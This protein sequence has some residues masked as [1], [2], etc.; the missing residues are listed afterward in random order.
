MKFI[1]SSKEEYPTSSWIKELAKHL[2]ITFESND[3]KIL[4]SKKPCLI[5]NPIANIISSEYDWK[6]K[7]YKRLKQN[8]QTVYTVERGYLPDCLYIDKYGALANSNSYNKKN[9]DKKLSIDKYKQVEKY[10]KSFIEDSSTL[11]EQKRGRIAEEG[12]YSKLRIKK[13]QIKV[14]VPLQKANDTV[15]LL[16]SDWIKGIKKFKTT[17][18]ELAQENPDILFLVKSHPRRLTNKMRTR[19]NI[20]NVD[21]FHYKDCIQHSDVIL[22]INSGVGLQAMMWNKPVI[23]IGKA[24]YHFKNINYKANNKEEIIKYIKEAKKPDTEE[25]KRFIYFLRYNFYT[26][27]KMEDLQPVKIN[28]IIFEHPNTTEKII[29]QCKQ[30]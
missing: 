6:K 15:I 5:W 8:N 26:E 28:K 24:F 7:L 4:K 2:D 13:K 12:F 18:N 14:F 3:S 9:W 19:D 16:W 21:D 11:E 29:I 10:I 17:I 22:T 20:I 23:T 27:C 25:V 1:T 30:T